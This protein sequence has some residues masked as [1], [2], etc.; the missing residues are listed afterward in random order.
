MLQAASSRSLDKVLAVFSAVA[1][2]WA[3]LWSM[4][5]PWR[6]APVLSASVDDARKFSLATAAAGAWVVDGQTWRDLDLNRLASLAAH[7]LSVLAQ[8]CIYR[9]LLVGHKRTEADET[10]LPELIAA[11]KQDQDPEHIRS[12]TPAF[13]RLRTLGFDPTTAIFCDRLPS[14][15]G[16]ARHLWMFPIVLTIISALVLATPVAILAI[17]AAF[18]FSGFVQIRLYVTLEHWKHCRDAIVV[19]LRALIEVERALGVAS[20]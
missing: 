8:H 5:S 14:P 13:E 2:R 17:F 19:M 11:F 3:M 1:S 7:D 6:D 4:A 15:P 12:I 9:S 10:P 18:A 20:K 16:W